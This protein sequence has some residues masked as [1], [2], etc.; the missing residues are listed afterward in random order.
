MFRKWPGDLRRAECANCE[1][2]QACAFLGDCAKYLRA[3]PVVSLWLVSANEADGDMQGVPMDGDAIDL[4][5][6]AEARREETQSMLAEAQAVV[7]RGDGGRELALAKTKLQE[8]GYW[9]AQ[10]L[11]AAGNG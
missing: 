7:G 2:P 8:V 3:Q 11:K 6:S 10:A 1:L 4:I 5:R 9:L